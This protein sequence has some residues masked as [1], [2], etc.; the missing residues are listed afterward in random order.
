MHLGGLRT[1]F[2]NWLYAHKA[3]VTGRY[4]LRIEDTDQ[5]RLIQS[6]I[7]QLLTSLKWAGLEAEEGVR[8]DEEK[9]EVVSVGEY[10]PYI[11][12]ERLHLYKHYVDELVKSGHGELKNQSMHIHIYTHACDTVNL[13]CMITLVIE[14]ESRDICCFHV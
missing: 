12:S 2:Y 8:Y 10:G 14:R 7:Y 6:S 11:Q 13:Q 5:K 1:A 4:I 3:G 9:K